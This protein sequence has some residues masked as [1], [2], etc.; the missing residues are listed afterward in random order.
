VNNAIDLIIV[1]GIITG[2]FFGTILGLI[3]RLQVFSVRA[4]RAQIRQAEA[5]ARRVSAGIRQLQDANDRVIT[6][7]EAYPATY[8]TF[9]QDVRDAVYAAHDSARQLEGR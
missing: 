1:P 8:G 3:I 2:M 4:R 7:L 9:P 6:E 5:Q